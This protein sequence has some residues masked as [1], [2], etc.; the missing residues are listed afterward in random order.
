MVGVGV[1]CIG[2]VVLAATVVCHDGDHCVEYF[3]QVVRWD[4]GCAKTENARNPTASTMTALIR[5]TLRMGNRR[6]V[7]RPCAGMPAWLVDARAVCGF[8]TGSGPDCW[9][10]TT[11]CALHPAASS[12]SRASPGKSSCSFDVCKCR[13]EATGKASEGCWL[14][15]PLGC[16]PSGGV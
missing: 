4:P 13:G 2:R 15:E 16:P 9:K 5:P 6:G 11:N 12:A 10:G 3:D 14:S 7:A 8:T 1:L